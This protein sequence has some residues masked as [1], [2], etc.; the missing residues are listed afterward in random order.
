MAVQDAVDD[1]AKFVA[2]EI[3]AII[4]NPKAVQTLACA[5]EFAELVQFGVH[6]ASWQTAELAQDLQ[7][8]FLR[9]SSELGGASRIKNDLKGRH[10]C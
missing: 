9:H 2:F 4:A 10:N 5:F 8:E 6:N 3:N 1:Q 7:L